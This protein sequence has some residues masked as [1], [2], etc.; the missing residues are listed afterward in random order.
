M[1]A[2]IM[3]VDVMVVIAVVVAMKV[4]TMRET[5]KLMIIAMITILNTI[6]AS[7][8]DDFNGY[9]NKDYNSTIMRIIIATI[10]TTTMTIMMMTTHLHNR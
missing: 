10:V 9:E 3:T 6:A 1:T 8:D 5:T 4:M 7:A 2:M